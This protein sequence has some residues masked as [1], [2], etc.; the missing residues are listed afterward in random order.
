MA[1]SYSV[2][3]KFV[4]SARDRQRTLLVSELLYPELDS[5]FCSPEGPDVTHTSWKTA[6]LIILFPLFLIPATAFATCSTPASP[7][8]VICTPGN[9]QTVNYP[10]HITA[11]AR[12]QNGLAI[13]KI[14]VY[15]DGFKVLGETNASTVNDIDYGTKEG[16]HSLS[17]N[18]WDSAG[19]LFQEKKTFSVLGGNG[20]SCAPGA[21]GIKFCSPG[22]GSYQPTNNFQSV[23]GAQG[24]NSPIVKLQ[25]WLD[26]YPVA[27][28]A[29]NLVTFQAGT[30]AGTHT[31]SAKAWDAA[32]HVFTA[33]ATF[34]TY[35]EGAC[36]YI[37]C[38]PGV[39]ITS[40]GSGAS[41]SSA[42]TLQADVQSN[43]APILAIKAY[44]DGVQVASSAGS[45]LTANLSA[46]TGMHRLTVQAW[47]TKGNLYRTVETFTV[48]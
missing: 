28:V 48:K 34:K 36:S 20:P 30:T 5:P 19:H 32:G 29:T 42:F 8:L 45:A 46:S 25:V 39:F 44:L 21:P 22:N 3:W 47:D 17:V 26:E 12:G 16:P 38:D 31:E 14:S 23:V 40:P 6:S 37:G 1:C 35:Y 2:L 27:T 7:G 11:A 13:V 24:E 41:V 10:V 9:G 43:P 15:I 18:A 4:T 33:S